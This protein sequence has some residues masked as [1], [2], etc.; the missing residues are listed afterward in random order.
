MKNWEE[1]EFTALWCFA[2]AIK[3]YTRFIRICVAYKNL[4]Y[5]FQHFGRYKICSDLEVYA[6]HL[7]HLKKKITSASDL[8]AIT[9]LYQL[10]FKQRLTK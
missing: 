1:A 6:L 9:Q 4:I 7:C 8:K 5:I 3:S 10:I 2:L